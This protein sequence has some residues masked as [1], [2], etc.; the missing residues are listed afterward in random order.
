MSFISTLIYMC[1][2]V[3]FCEARQP[4]IRADFS[5][6]P[7]TV[8]SG[9]ETEKP[10]LL[11]C[12]RR[13]EMNIKGYRYITTLNSL[14]VLKSKKHME[15]R[16]PELGLCNMT[17]KNWWNDW[18][19]CKTSVWGHLNGF[20]T[21]RMTQLTR[22]HATPWYVLGIDAGRILSCTYMMISMVLKWGSYCIW[23][24]YSRFICRIVFEKH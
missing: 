7:K 6:D 16:S 5:M 4:K 11:S 15:N 20:M 9:Q 18:S 24:P 12:R 13:N 8:L 1:Y 17:K 2:I 21:L 22:P 23:V 19:A 10:Y 3:L 14:N